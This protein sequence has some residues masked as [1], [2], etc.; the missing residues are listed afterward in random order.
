MSDTDTSTTDAAVT[1]EATTEPTAT[2]STTDT[3]VS[4]APDTA[5]AAPSNTE[6]VSGL[7]AS[8][9]AARADAKK[10]QKA[11]ADLQKASMTDQEKAIQTARDE[12]TAAV[13]RTF[14]ARLAAAE[15]K[16]AA[17][18]DGRDLSVADLIDMGQF[19][20]E[21][22]EV[23]VKAIKAAISKLPKL[24]PTDATSTATDTAPTP[25]RSGGDHR[26]GTGAGKPITEADLARM[27][28]DE[29]AE[30]FE[31]GRLGHLL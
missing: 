15:F 1:T 10:A 16:T 2:A 3:A 7:K 26:G 31:A 25:A 19:L 29:I 27:S 17:L 24:T 9:A 5:Q 20:G 22:G 8:L 21:D 18:A 23:D 6:D 28:Q 30:A 11:L 4:Q 12:A 14:G 13:T